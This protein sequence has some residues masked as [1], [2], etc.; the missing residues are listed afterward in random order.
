M[1]TYW[2][3]IVFGLFVTGST[4]VFKKIMDYKEKVD[5]ID[6]GVQVILKAKISENYE[7]LSNKECIS[8]Y[9]KELLMDLCHTYQELGDSPF[10]EGLLKKIEQ[11]PLKSDC[12]D[13]I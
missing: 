1:M 10:I 9:D 4:V 11:I 13:D 3:Q 2:I 7:R 12:D 6:S 8:M 5:K